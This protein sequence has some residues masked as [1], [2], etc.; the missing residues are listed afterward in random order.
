VEP[1]TG[2]SIGPL[3]ALIATGIAVAVWSPPRIG[4]AAGVAAPLAWV[5]AQRAL[6]EPE[7]AADIWLGWQQ[8]PYLVTVVALAALVIGR[9]R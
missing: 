5:A 4:V 9:N 3:V 6:G 1:A 7:I 8:H 2:W